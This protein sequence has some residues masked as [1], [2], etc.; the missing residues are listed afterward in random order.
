MGG[1]KG[2]GDDHEHGRWG[3]S[4]RLL[5][6]SALA[7]VVGCAH[8]A[9]AAWSPIRRLPLALPQARRTGRSGDTPEMLRDA[10]L[11]GVPAASLA[12]VRCPSAFPRLHLG[13]A[14]CPVVSSP[15]ERPGA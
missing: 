12:P 6:P 10:Q 2:T 14:S 7:H 4:A 11:S 8:V 3:M 5:I 9:P 15:M 13:E 1:G